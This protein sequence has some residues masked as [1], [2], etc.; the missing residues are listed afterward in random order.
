MAHPRGVGLDPCAGV[1]SKPA[2]RIVAI[3]AITTEETTLE[4]EITAA[5]HELERD[6]QFGGLGTR[7]GDGWVIPVDGEFV[8]TGALVGQAKEGWWEGEGGHAVDLTGV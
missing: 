4:A 1:A 3:H 8:A 2:T 6:Y 5:G 7:G